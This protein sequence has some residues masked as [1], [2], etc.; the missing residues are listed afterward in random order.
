VVFNILRNSAESMQQ[1][2]TEGTGTVQPQFILRLRHETEKDTVR[3]EISDNGPGMD[4]ETSKRVFEPFFTTKDLDSGTGL[5]LSVSYFII[6]E[7]HNG[8]LSVE[9]TPGKG[10]TFIIHLPLTDER[11]EKTM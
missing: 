10:S 8:E 2:V 4:S 7:N 9:S 5:G 11:S 3:I 6:K 1:I